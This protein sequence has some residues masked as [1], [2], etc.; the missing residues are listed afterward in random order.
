MILVTGQR[1]VKVLYESDYAKFPAWLRPE[2][3]RILDQTVDRAF[4]SAVEQMQA[5]PLSYVPSFFAPD[6]NQRYWQ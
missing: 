1:L 5:G 3:A 2:Y 6:A 4:T